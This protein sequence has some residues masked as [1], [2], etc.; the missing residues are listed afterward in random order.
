MNSCPVLSM[1]NGCIGW[2]P[3]SGSPLTTVAGAPFGAK[4]ESIV[5]FT[6]LSFDSAYSAPL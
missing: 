5:Y 1:T 3:A 2:S 4:A 6:I